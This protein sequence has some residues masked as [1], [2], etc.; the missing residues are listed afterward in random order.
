MLAST[1]AL[2]ADVSPPQESR[3]HIASTA[4]AAERFLAAIE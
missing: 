1:R 2:G 3:Q 4:T